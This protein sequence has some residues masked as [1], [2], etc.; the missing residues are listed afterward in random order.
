MMDIDQLS[1]T[2]FDLGGAFSSLYNLSNDF[3]SHISINKNS[4]LE[5]IYVTLNNMMVDLGNSAANQMKTAYENMCLFFKYED[6]FN[7]SLKEVDYPRISFSN[8][9]NF[10]DIRRKK[11]A[12]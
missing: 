2:L 7:N 12:L 4:S 3:N 10:P 1:T 8:L 5:N 9:F 6:K 11:L